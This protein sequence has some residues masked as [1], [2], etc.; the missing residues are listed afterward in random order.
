[1]AD[2]GNERAS[3]KIVKV[4]TPDLQDS[5]VKEKTARTM[6]EWY[7]HLDGRGGLGAGRRELIN[8]LYSDEKLDEWWAVTVVVEY[9]RARGQVEKDGKPKGY[10]V[11]AT[12]TIS[13]PLERVFD[14]FADKKSLDRWLGPKTR[15]EFKDGGAFAN[16]DGDAGTFSRIRANKDIRL[17]WNHPK[18]GTGTQVEVLFADKGKGKTGIT[19]NH[20]RIQSRRE[21]DD[22]RAG[23]GAAFDS[24][25]ELLEKG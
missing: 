7:A 1:M 19:L 21:A 16:A 14:A 8:H 10:S 24:L 2:A 18:I 11:C 12:K 25:K 15:I 4:D 22:L 3:M 9:E 5:V 17:A 23:W 13:A 20:T 6:K